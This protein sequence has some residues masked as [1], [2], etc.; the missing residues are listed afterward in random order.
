MTD[1]V[2]I[3]NTKVIL[4]VQSNDLI[5]EVLP[6]NSI[7]NIVVETNDNNIDIYQPTGIIDISAGQSIQGPKG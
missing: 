1:N 6:A 3:N 5:V 2:K 4:D 7:K